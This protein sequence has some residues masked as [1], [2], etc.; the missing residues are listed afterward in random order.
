MAN[1][2]TP[3]LISGE[4]TVTSAGAA[5]AV[6][7]IQRVKSITIIAKSTNVGQVYVGGSDVASTTNDGLDAG[8]ALSVEAA[9]WMDLAD[10]YIDADIH[11]PIASLNATTNGVSRITLG[12]TP[13]KGLAP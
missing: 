13:R 10:L 2:E 12:K 5:E 6:G 4:K 8:E 7:S 9:G 3:V 1:S 11:M